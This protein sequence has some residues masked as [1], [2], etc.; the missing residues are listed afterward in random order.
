MEKPVFLPVDV[1]SSMW[2]LHPKSPMRH[3]DGPKRFCLL[4]SDNSGIGRAWVLGETLNADPSRKRGY[5]MISSILDWTFRSDLLSTYN[6][7][8]SSTAMPS[9]SQLPVFD[10][11]NGFC[12]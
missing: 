10:L 8:T 3:D 4:R 12:F 5:A 11:G 2:Q 6:P 9:L 1:I 7:V